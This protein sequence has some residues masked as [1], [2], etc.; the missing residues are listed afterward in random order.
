MREEFW[1]GGRGG[2]G[3]WLDGTFSAIL[4]QIDVYHLSSMKTNDKAKHKKNGQGLHHLLQECTGHLQKRK[5][6]LQG[7]SSFIIIIIPLI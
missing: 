3:H 7:K 1:S 4:G 6:F 5:P 2:V